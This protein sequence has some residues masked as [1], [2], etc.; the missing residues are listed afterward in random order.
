MDWD[1]FP[2]LSL[3]WRIVDLSIKGTV[4]WLASFHKDLTLLPT[5]RSEDKEEAESLIS[6]Q[7]YQPIISPEYSKI[8]IL[9]WDVR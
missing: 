9:L 3:E 5:K 2:H 6:L 1:L 8:S 7:A 4:T